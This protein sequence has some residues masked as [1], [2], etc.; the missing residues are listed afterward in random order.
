MIAKINKINGVLITIPRPTTFGGSHYRTIPITG[1]EFVFHASMPI[2]TATDPDN[3]PM[4]VKNGAA[5][6]GAG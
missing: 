5:R 3:G 1:T 6:G 4:A 2:S